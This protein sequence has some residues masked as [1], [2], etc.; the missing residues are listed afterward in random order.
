MKNIS[1]SLVL[2]FISYILYLFFFRIIEDKESIIIFKPII[3]A[4][5]AFYYVNQSYV[6]KNI[7]HFVIIGLLFISDNMNLFGEV[8]FHEIS[9]GVYLIVLFTL[10]FLIVKDSKLLTKGSSF[11][12]YFGI[13][14]SILVLL[15]VLAKLTSTFILKTKIHHY[16]FI[17]NYIV[18]FLSVLILSFYNFF[19]RKTLSS[20]FLVATLM[21]LFLSDLFSVINS[22]YFPFRP[23]VYISCLSELPVYYFLIKYFINRDLEKIKS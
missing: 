11:D 23:L 20:K 21:C 19:K 7:L 15:F 13:I 3:L 8:K 9:I 17:L 6:K 5:I 12:K 2:H 4:S 22:Y 18:V 10:L 16:Y 14:I 1:P